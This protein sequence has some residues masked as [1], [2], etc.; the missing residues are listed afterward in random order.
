MAYSVANFRMRFAK[1]S[2]HWSPKIIA[3]M[4]DYQFK[5]VKFQGDF[6]WH[7]HVETDEIFI[8]LEEEMEIEFRD[9]KITLQSGEMDVVPKSAEHKPLAQR[10]W[11]IL[12]VEPMDTINTGDTDD[13]LTADTDIWI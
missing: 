6:V 1:F 2:N 11:K 12:L 3:Q 9:G 7:K 5:L 8:V 10:E 4:N 13:E